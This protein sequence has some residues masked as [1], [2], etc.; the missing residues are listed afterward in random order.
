MLK[1]ISTPEGP[2]CTNTEKNIDELDKLN[3]WEFRGRI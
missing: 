3:N 2:V 1:S